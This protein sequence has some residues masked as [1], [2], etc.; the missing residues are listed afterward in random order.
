M[1]KGVYKYFLIFLLVFGVVVFDSCKK[2]SENE[3]TKP[4]I[5]GDLAFS[6]PNYGAVNSTYELWATGITTPTEGVKYQWICSGIRKDT[7]T[8]Q[9]VTITIPDS[10]ATYT[11]TLI[12]SA[13]GYYGKSVNKTITSVDASYCKSLTD[14]PDNATT[15]TD[16][17]DNKSYGYVTIGSL[18]WMSENLEWA[19]A[20][21]GYARVD[22][23]GDVFG[24]Y[25]TWKEATGGVAATGLGAGPQGVCPDGWT[26]PTNEDWEDLAK[27][28]NG[29][30]ELSFLN[31][32]TNC[33]LQRR[34]S[35]CTFR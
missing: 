4:S 33:L 31:K 18:D 26:I 24:R 20:G 1:N 5:E 16:S 34:S 32:K 25:Y 15:F 2:K 28:A 3:E 8:T 6:L 13:E 35:L 19:G 21:I 10:L 27:A 22:I 23:M 30:K 7:V 9:N 12:V 29:G 14:I 17:R 11:I